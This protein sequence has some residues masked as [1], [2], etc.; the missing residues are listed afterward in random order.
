MHMRWVLNV[1]YVRLATR[2]RFGQRH[3]RAPRQDG[4]VPSTFTLATETSSSARAL[5]DLSLD[6]DADSIRLGQMYASA[7]SLAL[8]T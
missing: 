3:V 5:F 6:I 1:P 8:M 4:G 2:I 7:E